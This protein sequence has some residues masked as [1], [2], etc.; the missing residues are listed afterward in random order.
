MIR[1]WPWSCC[2]DAAVW[3]PP[4]ACWLL[5][6]KSEQCAVGLV[7]CQALVPSA[8]PC[9]I[10]FN[11]ILHILPSGPELNLAG[12]FK[13][14]KLKLT[15]LAQSEECPPLELQVGPGS[16]QGVF[17]LLLQARGGP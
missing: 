14:T 2:L 13:K 8:S 17:F 4:S 12:D 7:R 11:S 1:A 9:F 5:V 15:W 3:A 10:S 6:V 16:C